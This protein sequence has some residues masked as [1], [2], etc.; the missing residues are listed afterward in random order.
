MAENNNNRKSKRNFSLEKPV[1]RRFDIEKEVKTLLLLQQL[2][3]NQL[4][5]SRVQAHS[6]S[7]MVILRSQHLSHKVKMIL[8]Q[9]LQEAIMMVTVTTMAV[10]EA[11]AAR[12]LLSGLLLHL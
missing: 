12:V 11:T 5:L 7:Q 8:Q 3:Q 9:H 4:R 2:L 1:E 6:K 10:T